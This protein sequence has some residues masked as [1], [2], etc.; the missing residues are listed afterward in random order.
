M[1]NHPSRK[2]AFLPPEDGD[3][4]GLSYEVQPMLHAKQ[5]LD[6]FDSYFMEDGG[7]GRAVG[8]CEGQGTELRCP[9]WGSEGTH[10]VM[11]E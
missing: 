9:T 4:S 1:T 11:E 6:I 10:E 7:F 3:D 8:G 5:L 2:S